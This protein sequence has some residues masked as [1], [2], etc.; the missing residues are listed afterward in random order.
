MTGAGRV[1]T[2]ARMRS[3]QGRRWRSSEVEDLCL[4]AA[5]LVAAELEIVLDGLGA[6]CAA[7]AALATL[8]LALRRRLPVASFG[9]VAVLVPTLDRAL[10]SPWGSNANALVFV[11]LAAAYS[12]G[13]HA[14]LRRS[15]PALLGAA[16]WLATLE[17]VWGDGEDYAFFVLLLGVPWLSGRGV[18]RYRRQAERLREV[19]TRLERERAVSERVAIARE[20]HRMAHETH[21]AIAHAVGEMVL[22]ASGALEVLERDPERARA[23][24]AAVQATGREAVDALRAILGILRSGDASPPALGREEGELGGLGVPRERSWPAFLDAGLALVLLAVGTGYALDAV[25]LAGQ[26]APAL[27]I[28]A[29]AAATVV[30]RRRRPFTAL[31]LAVATFVGDALLVGGNPGSPATIGALLLTTFSAAAHLDRRTGI[32][33]ACLALGVPAAIALALAGADAADVLLPVVIVGIPWLSGRAI[34][35]YRRQGAELRVLAQRLVRERD[36]RAR[37]AVLDERARVARELH[38]SIAHA[39]SVMV[40]QAGAAEQ[41]LDSTPAQA[42]VALQAIQEVG[43]DALDQLATLLGLLGSADD[44]PPLAPRSGLAEL[45]RLLDT[46]RQ[47][48]LPVRLA[49]LGEPVALPAALDGAAYRIIQEAL[50]NA[51]K[52]AGAEPTNVTVRYA[53]DG[54]HLDI[55]DAGPRAS[56]RSTGGHGLA[57]MRERVA[58]HGGRMHA[59]PT[60]GGSG[61]AVSVFLPHAPVPRADPGRVHV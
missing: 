31:V 15:L 4:V 2:V 6:D 55:V 21:D 27:L 14:P 34:A 28:Q 59:G 12:V 35:A 41:V 20:R 26:R 38:D 37:L 33:A 11:V 60:A 29:L 42:R 1:G 52:H 13:A 24:L 45:E 7:L 25:A 36:A 44:R 56:S 48:G 51:L 50:T 61:F 3:A 47:A 39:V 40:L 9:C 8:P 22:Q 46:V 43:R 18:R 19:A 53:A 57:G 54:I 49:T 58:H 5:L 23:A 30:L 10:G 16:A 17:A 32:A